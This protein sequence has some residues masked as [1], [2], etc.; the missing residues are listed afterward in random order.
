[1]GGLKGSMQVPW[2][3]LEIGITR[4]PKD[5]LVY[6]C[7]GPM[8]PTSE[9]GRSLVMGPGPGVMGS[10]EPWREPLEGEGP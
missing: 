9:P 3:P 4:D 2:D 10:L 5:P 8:V 6:Y 7:C 1:M